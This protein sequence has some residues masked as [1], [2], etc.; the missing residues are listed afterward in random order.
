MLKK[1]SEQKCELK[2]TEK[3]ISHSIL[4][5]HISV[6]GSILQIKD[7]DLKNKVCEYEL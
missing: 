7:I 5:K 1:V 2:V 6:K 4:F 3:A